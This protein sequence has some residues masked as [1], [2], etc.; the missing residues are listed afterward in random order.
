M[1]VLLGLRGTNKRR[2]NAVM[3]AKYAGG[4]AVDLAGGMG[5]A[6][7]INE[8]ERETNVRF[9]IFFRGAKREKRWPYFPRSSSPP[10]IG[11]VTIGRQD[12]AQT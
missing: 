3:M 4:M 9:Y 10:R 5:E 6:K 7:E 1:R 8:V 11:E 12:L 2:R